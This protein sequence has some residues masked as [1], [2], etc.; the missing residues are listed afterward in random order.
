[1]GFA[2]RRGRPIP[3]WT[4]PV[5]VVVSAQVF[6]SATGSGTLAVVSFSGD[7]SPSERKGNFEE[8]KEAWGYEREE[9]AAMI[10]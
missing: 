2:E 7:G 5:S 4:A 6:G 9:E 10:V 1:M 3:S 8:D